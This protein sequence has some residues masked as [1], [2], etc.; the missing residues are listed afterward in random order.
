VNTR[1]CPTRPAHRSE[2]ERLV[3]LLTDVETARLRELMERDLS[4]DVTLVHFTKHASRLVVPGEDP[5]PSCA[6]T[7]ALL[8]ELAATSDH[9]S[10]EVHDVAAEPD[11]AREQGIDKVPATRII[12]PGARGAVRLF[13]LPGGY[14]FATLI[15]DV[16]DVGG[17]R[18]DLSDDA[19]AA[20]DA[21]TRDVHLQVFVT[22]TCP[23]CPAAVRTAHQLA[24]A[25]PRVTADVI[26]VNDFPHLAERYDVMA[27]PKVVIDDTVS[28]E[29][30]L[31]ESEFLAFLAEA[32][33]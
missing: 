17:A 1:A 20:L 6:D 33:G 13:G 30:A 29:G 31:P 11:V 18:D 2:G 12:G 9:L 25:S 14:E 3:S 4:G 5:C 28:F 19:H 7:V 27:V 21:L 26:V 24:M 15:E 22:P 8:G 16:I 23:H 10:L 32:T